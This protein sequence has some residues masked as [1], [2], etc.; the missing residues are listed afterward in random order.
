M[1]PEQA[2]TTLH[3]DHVGGPHA[4]YRKWYFA[5]QLDLVYAVGQ[6]QNLGIERLQSIKRANGDARLATGTARSLESALSQWR[7]IA[8]YLLCWGEAAQVCFVPGC[9]C[10]I[11]RCAN[12]F[13][14]SPEC[15]NRQDPVPEGLFLRSVVRPLYRFICNQATNFRVASLFVGKRTMAISLAMTTSANG[16]GIPKASRASRSITAPG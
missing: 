7:Q 13:Y 12:G 1:S 4:N 10:F 8:L 14:H 15:Q 9:L 5:A 2:L 3:A 16:S 11:F 6:T